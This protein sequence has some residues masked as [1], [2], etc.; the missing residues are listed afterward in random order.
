MSLI[1]HANS[2]DYKVDIILGIKQDQ[3]YND[4]LQAR[5]SNI[6][7]PT[8]PSY[9]EHYTRDDLQQVLL[10]L[11][12]QKS[13]YHITQW[14]RVEKI[15]Q[16][17]FA[18]HLET[19][20]ITLPVHRA[21]KLFSTKFSQYRHDT[22]RQ[23]L[24]RSGPS[25]LPAEMQGHITYAYPMHRFPSTK[26]LLTMPFVPVISPELTTSLMRDAVTTNGTNGVNP[27][28]DRRITPRCLQELYGIDK[29]DIL[30]TASSIGVAGFLEE[31]ANQVDAAQFIE[32]FAKQNGTTSNS[33]FELVAIKEGTVKQ[34]LN[35]GTD[36]A[37]LD[38]QYV[39]G[40]VNKMP[41][42]FYSV[43]GRAT[44]V[45]KNPQAKNDNEPFLDLINHLDSLPDDKLP[46]VLSISYGDIEQSIPKEYAESVCN[47]F[48]RL[49]LRGVSTL[50]ASGD[51]G[52][53]DGAQ[54]LTNDNPANT[55]A[56]A[57]RFQPE[58]P[59]SC[60]FVTTVGG[61]TGI[62]EHAAS[63]TGGG[64]SNY[65][66]R[67]AYQ[68]TQV[69][70]FLAQL[71]KTHSDMF[72]ATGRGYPDISAQSVNFVVTLKGKL[73]LVSGTSASTPVVASIIALLNDDLLSRG[74]PVL[75]FLNPWL[76]QLQAGITPITKGSNPGCGTAGF[77]A[78]QGW[79]PV[80]GLGTPQFSRLVAQ[81][82]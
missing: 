48:M 67:P 17:E 69:D 12:D 34:D 76:Y 44:Q 61:T 21:E 57:V 11:K 27:R 10:A 15:E 45:S 53:G 38:I 6:S 9:G 66:S 75:G 37:A 47:G 36:E 71:G 54:C 59:A 39:K 68:S 33:T 2:R 82:Q 16:Y 35:S 28:C 26:S 70:A 19:V 58:F 64:F 31:V 55:G 5:L 1:E 22:M 56:K 72:N 41:T 52:V 14:L 78:T 30:S 60:P 25:Q 23:I 7:D 50:V 46:K 29:K 3:S 40:L 74:K 73:G 32:S 42:V 51:S 18:S 80:T 24:V 62:N 43:G 77:H 81:L 13:V 8:H 4:L 63:F 20:R 79:S 49:A 65:F